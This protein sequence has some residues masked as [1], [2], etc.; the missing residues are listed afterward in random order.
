MSLSTSANTCYSASIVS[1]IRGTMLFVNRDHQ[2][3]EAYS[4]YLEIVLTATESSTGLLCACLPLTKPIVIHFTRWIQKV[5]GLDTNHQGWSSVSA[6]AKNTEKDMKITRVVD[7]HVQLLPMSK[8]TNTQTSFQD[9]EGMIVE[10]PWQSVG[11]YEAKAF[12]ES[13]V[14]QAPYSSGPAKPESQST[15]GTW[16]S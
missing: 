2:L 13:V 6:S 5:R 4:N 11:P 10:K 15:W 14:P 8:F 7:Y 16:K 9:R 12:C 1:L 3:N